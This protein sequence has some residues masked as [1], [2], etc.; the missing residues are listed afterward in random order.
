MSY[1][2]VVACSDMAH[3]IVVSGSRKSGVTSVVINLAGALQSFGFS[4]LIVG[5]K[6]VADY[7]G[8]DHLADKGYIVHPSG[9]QVL[10]NDSDDLDDKASYII[11]DESDGSYEHV[12]DAYRIVVSLS[13]VK[14]SVGGRRVG[15]VLNRVEKSVD[16]HEAQELLGIPLIGVIPEDSLI[17]QAKKV[18][19]PVVL[20]DADAQVS[21][22]YKRLASTIVGQPYESTIPQS[23]WDYVLARLGFR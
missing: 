14:I 18:H 19:H 8:V 17:D 13:S 22:A 5:K 1:K 2:Q 23:W 16:V 7:L 10:L 15:C 20:V 9:L 4:C 3:H 21:V 12:K 11:F 6:G